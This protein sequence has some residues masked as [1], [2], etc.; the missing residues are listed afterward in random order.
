M[1]P[2]AMKVLCPILLLSLGACCIDPRPVRYV[3][4]ASY[5]AAWYDYSFSTP[6]GYDYGYRY[7]R[8]YSCNPYRPTSYRNCSPSYRSMPSS[9]PR[10]SHSYGGGHGGS[11]GS[12]PQGGH[13]AGSS[14]VGSHGGHR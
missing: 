1:R 14:S 13:S 10:P 4:D 8:G 7:G 12:H 11:G 9:C 2:I 3:S 5:G 6:G